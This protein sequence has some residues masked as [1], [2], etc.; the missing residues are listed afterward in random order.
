MT[1]T[2]VFRGTPY[3]YRTNSLN[4]FRLILAATVLFAHSYYTTGNGEGPHIRGENLGGWAVAGFFV[5]SGFLI[6][7]S[8]MRTKAGEYLLHRVVR[9]FPAFIVCLLVTA[10]VLGPIAML[11]QFGT[12]SGYFT[13]P[14][15]PLQF[16]WSNI[17]LYMHDYTIGETLSD[18]P[19]RGAWNGSLW[20][21]YYEFV[22]YVLIWVLGALSWFRRNALLAV[23]AF[24]AATTA[25][26]L[27][28]LMTRLGMDTS[29]LL[30]LKLAPF[31][32]GGACVYFLIERFGVNRWLAVMA[33]IVSL[34]LI[35]IVPVWGGQ[36]SA[37]FLAYG[38]LWLAT[39]IPQP[40]WVARN[41]VSYGF[42]IYAW[43]VQQLLALAGLGIGGGPV[44]LIAYNLVVALITFAL[45]YLSWVLVE[46][47]A[48]RRIRR[49]AS[50][51]HRTG[52]AL[53]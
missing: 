35:L 47:P 8:R 32:L 25:Y 43:P 19:Y 16:V 50:T 14:V 7:R 26:A 20:T 39:L 29:F 31:F 17:G 6:T 13:T 10:F 33:L 27:S 3:P 18:V 36:L 9:I 46:R 30:L 1:A 11:M 12:L 2:A 40:A 53:S 24:L 38:L 5:I 23:L 44:G 52:V 34:G 15:T 41:D 37:P 22:C 21:L 48:M 49:A 51:P 4:L 28:P 45:A 42:Y